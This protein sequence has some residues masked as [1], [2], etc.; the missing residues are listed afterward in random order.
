MVFCMETLL[1]KIDW[2]IERIDNLPDDIIYIIFDF[3]G[4]VELYTHHK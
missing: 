1:E 4:Q 3:P 2:L